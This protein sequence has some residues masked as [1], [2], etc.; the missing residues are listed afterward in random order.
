MINKSKLAAKLSDRTLLSK[1][2]SAIV[3]DNLLDIIVE[4]LMDDEDVSLVGFGKFYLYEHASRPV[5]NPKTQEPMVL[6]NYK[7]LRFKC[8]DVLKNKLKE[9]FKANK[10]R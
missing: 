2:E 5:R 8:S 1:K 4:S 9:Q 6:D 7:S 10:K 3:V